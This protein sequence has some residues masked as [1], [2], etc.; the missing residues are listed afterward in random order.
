MILRRVLV[1]VLV[2]ALVVMVVRP[3]PAEAIEPTGVILIASAAVAVLLIVGYLIAANV[4]E[5]KTAMEDGRPLL[6]V[7]VAPTSESP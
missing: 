4:H 1:T 3:L 5:S 2:V 7:F 6:V